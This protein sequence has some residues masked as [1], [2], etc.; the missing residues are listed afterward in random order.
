MHPPTRT[1]ESCRDRLDAAIGLGVL[2]HFLTDVHT[3]QTK[4]RTT[5]SY[6][7]PGST[8]TH[9]DVLAN[10]LET[11]VMLIRTNSAV[12]QTYHDR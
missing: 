12:L 5:C 1:P 4:R 7:F 11:Y 2:N 10:V 9:S 3:Q 8:F 6:E